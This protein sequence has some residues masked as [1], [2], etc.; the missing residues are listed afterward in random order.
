MDDGSRVA[1]ASLNDSA[2]RVALL[3][4]LQ[5]ILCLDMRTWQKY[6]TGV[7][8]QSSPANYSTWCTSPG[9][10]SNETELIIFLFP[11]N[12]NLWAKKGPILRIQSNRRTHCTGC[13]ILL[14]FIQQSQ[15]EQYSRD[16]RCLILL[17]AHL[18]IQ[19]FVLEPTQPIIIARWMASTSGNSKQKAS[20]SN[21]SP[22]SIHALFVC[23]RTKR[24]SERMQSS[25]WALLPTKR[26]RHHFFG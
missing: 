2:R 25:S 8:Q 13:Q 5:K 17:P 22:M 18:W 19:S 9:Q 24:V 10:Q 21:H 20:E 23:R 6:T 15:P 4:S 7:E 1:H 26:A 11:K 16:T 14:R 12:H 3:F